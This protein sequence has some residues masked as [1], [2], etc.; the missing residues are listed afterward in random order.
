MGAGV[1]LL[2]GIGL[3]ALVASSD[4]L[5]G[6]A[7][8]LRFVIRWFDPWL[9][10]VSDVLDET[11]TDLSASVVFVLLVPAVWGVWGRW[12]AAVFIAAGAAT[13]L[14]RLGSLVDRP[15]PDGS[16]EW[17]DAAS[18]PGGYPSGHVVYF[19]LV[20]GSIALFAATDDRR[21]LRAVAWLCTAMV[22][23]VG[24]A[25]L[26]ALDHWPADVI[27]AYLLAFPV[28][29]VVAHLGHHLP[30]WW[31]GRPR[32]S[33]DDEAQSPVGRRSRESVAPSADRE[34]RG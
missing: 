10:P 2:L 8:T 14:A 6:E 13:S 3:T 32:P 23:V 9:S 28:L 33:V 12:A 11:F 15:R 5:P 24:P 17:S 21:R 22:I 7:A 18:G 26:V 31:S 34:N 25:R 19:V 16:L 20:F 30:N 27:G 1:S 29:V 4:L